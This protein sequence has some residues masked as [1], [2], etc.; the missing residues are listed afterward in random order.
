MLWGWRELVEASI[1]R[2]PLDPK[3][4]RVEG[5]QA[6]TLDSVICSD[7][8]LQRSTATVR[9]RHVKPA[10][11]ERAEAVMSNFDERPR[12][13]LASNGVCTM[14]PPIK[15]ASKSTLDPLRS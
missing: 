13:R 11:D 9:G 1:N 4:V 3:I 8:S 12:R 15:P 14:L 6:G 2:R 7:A 5:C 10:D